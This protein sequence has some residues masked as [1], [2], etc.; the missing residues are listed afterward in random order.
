MKTKLTIV[1]IGG[2]VIND[3]L[4]LNSFLDDFAKL[5]G[6][7]ILVHG[8]GKVATELSIELGISPNLQNGRRITSQADLEVVTMVYAGLI[9]KNI[10]AQLQANNC[11][12]VGLSGAD[13]N[14]I[15]AVK[16]TPVP[17]DFGHVGD[18]TNVN[19]TIIE[20]LLQHTITPV[21]CAIT[22]DNAGNL[23]NTNADTIA[24]EI[25]IALSNSYDTE[26]IYCFEKKGVLADLNDEESV[27]QQI[28]LETYEKLKN[29]GLIHTGMLPKM[30]NCFYAL[31]NMVSKVQIGNHAMILKKNAICTTL[32]LN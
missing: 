25:A 24:S 23:L 32:S 26:L 2:N 8:G 19:T 15:Q 12:A 10:T 11:N 21:F 29:N 27:I 20:M 6:P 18:V 14:T 9:N 3:T 30:S 16:R 13:L 31:Q 28:N 7:K 4:L 17:I 5:E 1:K 22:H